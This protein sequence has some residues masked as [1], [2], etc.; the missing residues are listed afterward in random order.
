MV[1]I[2]NPNPGAAAALAALTALTIDALLGDP[3]RLWAR[4]GHPVVWW[5]R[6]I[7]W[8]DAR[9][10][11]ED[12]SPRRR[13]AGGGALCAALMGGGAA[14]GAA[15]GALAA[16]PLGWLLVGALCAPWL[17]QRSLFEHVEAVRAPLAAGDDARARAALGMIVGRDLNC[18]DAGAMSG[19]AI[20]SLAE[21]W[22]DGVGA[23]VFWLA[24]LGPAGLIAYKAVN[25]ADSMIGNRTPRHAAFGWASA[26]VDDALNWAPARLTASALA[27]AALWTPQARCGPALR[28]A[29][30]DAPAH[31][32]LNAGWPEA[33]CAGALGLAIGG[34]RAYG[35]AFEDGPVMGSGGRAPNGA[36][37]LGAASVNCA[38]RSSPASARGPRSGS[39]TAA[40][41]S[42]KCSRGSRNNGRSTAS[43]R[44]SR[45]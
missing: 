9:F 16:A 35:G 44:S 26:R 7:A 24:L 34:P 30:R 45:A 31:R 41:D 27:L 37:D 43:R 23:P 33:A 11:R 21:S 42:A 38:S 12:A 3:P 6:A 39:P 1:D 32:S 25:T 5:G 22:S 40:S 14:A 2:V 18:A 10:N 17:A 19:A 13:R 8:A 36:E 29:L 15:V 4:I 20:E 28:A